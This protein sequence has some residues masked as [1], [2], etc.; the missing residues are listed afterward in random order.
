MSTLLQKPFFLELS[1]R[2]IALKV[3]KLPHILDVWNKTLL[4]P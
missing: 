1:T 2:T 4:I 3:L